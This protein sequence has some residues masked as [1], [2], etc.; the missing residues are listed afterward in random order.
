MSKVQVP[1]TTETPVL[2]NWSSVLY[3]L[4]ARGLPVDSQPLSVMRVMG[5]EHYIIVKRAKHNKLTVPLHFVEFHFAEFQIAETL[6]LLISLNPSLTLTLGYLA[7]CKIIQI[8]Q[9][10]KNTII[11]RTEIRRNE[12]TPN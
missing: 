4:D 1:S 6:L 12:N 8:R 2:T 7:F 10:G 9:N 11:R 5:L 3:A